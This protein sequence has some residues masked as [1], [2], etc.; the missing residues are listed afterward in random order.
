MGEP[1]VPLPPDDHGGYGGRLA[2]LFDHAFAE[3]YR[4]VWRFVTADPPGSG[5]V[6]YPIDRAIP[7]S[8][9]GGANREDSGEMAAVRAG[10]AVGYRRAFAD[11]GQAPR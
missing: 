8:A 1:S 5:P 6:L 4:V 3:T 2:G 10:A 11:A 7:T 9:I